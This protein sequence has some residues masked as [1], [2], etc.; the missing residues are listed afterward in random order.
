MNIRG[1]IA[2][3]ILLGVTAGLAAQNRGSRSSPPIP[4][5]PQ[6]FFTAEHRIRVVPV[7]TGLSHPW[8]VALLPS[9]PSTP[10]GAGDMLVTERDGRL[11][12]VRNGVLDPTPVSGV[13]AVHRGALAGLL[14]IALHPKFAENRLV[15]LSYSKPGD[16]KLST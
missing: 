5:L 1:L 12:I 16:G 11:R 2:V 10:L 15:Y 13:P 7:A 4:S 14:D 8:S 6:T 3:V 9:G